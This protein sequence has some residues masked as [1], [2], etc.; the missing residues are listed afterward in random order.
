MILVDESV[1]DQDLDLVPSASWNSVAWAHTNYRISTVPAPKNHNLFR[2]FT[3]CPPLFCAFGP[4]HYQYS[5]IFTPV[6]I[7]D[8]GLSVISLS[9]AGYYTRK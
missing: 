4:H 7:P 9:S 8:L 3:W 1:L 5:L 2:K 6:I